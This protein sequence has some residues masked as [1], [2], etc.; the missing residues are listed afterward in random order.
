MKNNKKATDAHAPV[1][2][3]KFLLTTKIPKN[4]Y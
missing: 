1:A 2:N 3:K 4:Y